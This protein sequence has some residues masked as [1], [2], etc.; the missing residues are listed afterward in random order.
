V[1]V[2]LHDVRHIASLAR[3]GVSDSEATALA[4][5]LNGILAHMDVLAS[6]NTDGIDEPSAVV[7][8]PMPLRADQGPPI[9]MTVSIDAFSPRTQDGL[10][11]VPRLASHESVV[12]E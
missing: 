2:T 5:Q 9:A 12:E 1:S 7:A 8:H 4:E 3:L 6:V 11:L 10:L